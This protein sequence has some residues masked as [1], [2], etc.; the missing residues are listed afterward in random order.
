MGYANV[1]PLFGS[2]NQLLAALALISCAVFLK[3]TNRQGWMLWAPMF[4]MLAVTFTALA[5]S[6]RN[7]W[8]N[9]AAFFGGNGEINITG[10]V[11]QLVFGILLLA[12]GI[13]VAFQGVRKLGEKA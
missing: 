7:N 12:L 10:S 8:R 5:F 6:I 11:L 1:W 13:M 9:A 4:I 3:K 2:A